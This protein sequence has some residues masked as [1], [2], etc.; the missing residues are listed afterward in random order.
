MTVDGNH[1]SPLDAMSFFRRSTL[2]VSSPYLW[3]VQLRS[4][5]LSPESFFPPGC[6]IHSRVSPTSTSWTW[7][8]PFFLL[9]LGLQ[10]FSP[11]HPIPDLVPLLPSLSLFH[12]VPSLPLLSVVDL[13]SLLSG[14]EAFSLW[15]VN[16]L[17]FCGLYPR[18]SAHFLASIH[19]LLSTYHAWFF[20][21]ELVYSG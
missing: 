12:P 20:G 4:L 8:F 7:L 19:L 15:F 21:F 2:E 3:A 14:T 17:E 6:L 16:L 18:Y 13:F 11:C 5:P 10:Y 1:I 9:P